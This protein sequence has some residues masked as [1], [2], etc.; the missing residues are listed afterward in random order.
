[1]AIS[2]F[3]LG[4]YVAIESVRSLIDRRETAPSPLGIIVAAAS[5]LVMPALGAAKKPLAQTGV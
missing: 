3:V 2:F 4:P 1:M 5:L